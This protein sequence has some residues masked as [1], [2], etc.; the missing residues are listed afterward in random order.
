[1]GSSRV[2]DTLSSKDQEKAHS[3]RTTLMLN[4]K[5]CM[6]SNILRM[7]GGHSM[8]MSLM[9]PMPWKK[10]M[11]STTY[12]VDCVADGDDA[13]E[14]NIARITTTTHTMA[15]M[16]VRVLWSGQGMQLCDSK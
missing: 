9:A 7:M 2:M 1:M 14:T 10:F 12:L 13:V 15:S 16:R 8:L 6:I 4:E 11:P 5:Y 3:G